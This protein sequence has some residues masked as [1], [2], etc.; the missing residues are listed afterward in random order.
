MGM[1]RNTILILVL[2]FCQLTLIILRFDHKNLIFMFIF[3]WEL[4]L[5]VF[6]AKAEVEFGSA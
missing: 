1:I 6:M 2:V 5:I 3:S 4:R